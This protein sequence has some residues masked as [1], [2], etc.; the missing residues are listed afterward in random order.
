MCYLFVNRLRKA[1]EPGHK[2]LVTLRYMST[3]ELYRTSLRWNHRLAHNTI[4]II[5]RDTCK[6]IYEEYLEEIWTMPS[7]P[8]GWKEV[9]EGFSTR[10]NFHHCVGALDGKHIAIVKPPKTGS[11]YR[12]YKGFFSVVLMAAVDANYS[13]LWFSVGH[14]GRNSDAGI[15]RRSPLKRKLER[16]Q[17]GLPDAEPLPHD[18]TRNIPY[19]FIGDEAF[20]L[21][22]WLMKKFPNRGC[23]AFH[24]IF[25]YR[26]SRARLVV[27]N[28]F[29]IMAN[30]WRCFTTTMQQPPK[31]VCMIVKAAL[32]MQDMIRKRR[33]LMPGEVD[34]VDEQANIVQE[35]SWRQNVRLYDSEN[36]VG[37]R[38][39]LA[40]R[41]QRNY[42]C[43]YYNAPI[44]A[45]PWQRRRVLMNDR[46][47][48][49]EDARSEDEAEPES[50]Q[51]RR[52][53]LTPSRI[54]T[55]IWTLTHGLSRSELSC[56]AYFCQVPLKLY[57]CIL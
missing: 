30:R 12:N 51:N 41:S 40:A 45:V 23:T 35:G 28:A 42:L 34:V 14:P 11:L 22:S 54:Q 57:L 52:R 37:N 46:R 31:T 2:L 27:E 1:V 15:F 36:T 50:E 48:A 7:T 25:N 4:S 39:M 8:E 24:R 29:G 19:F 17:L 20:P 21:N 43:E 55:L 26:I 38:V 3:G 53:T 49:E 47:Q 56:G 5:I 6:A 10:W 13:F 32:T 9:A 33:P 18:H 16:G 44:G